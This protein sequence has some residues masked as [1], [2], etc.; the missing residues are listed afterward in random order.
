M[1][2][3]YLNNKDILKEI[4]KSKTTYCYYTHPEYSEYDIILPDIGKLNKKNTLEGRRLRAERLAKVAS[5][6]TFPMKEGVTQSGE[7]GD[8]GENNNGQQ[9]WG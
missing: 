5:L 3:N 2:H 1:R 7:R 8:T 9:A 6:K 4:H